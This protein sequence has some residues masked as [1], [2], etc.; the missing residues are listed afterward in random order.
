MF[1]AFKRKVRNMNCVKHDYDM[2]L[3]SSV[4]PISFE[5]AVAL[6]AAVASDAA[7]ALDAAVSASVCV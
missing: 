3:A 2:L 6:D 4:A 5:A 1:L 7:A